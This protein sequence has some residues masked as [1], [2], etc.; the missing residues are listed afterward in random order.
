MVKRRSG[1]GRDRVDTSVRRAETAQGRVALGCEAGAGPGDG[2]EAGHTCLAASSVWIRLMDCT[3]FPKPMP[4]A[5]MQPRQ[6]WRCAPWKAPYMNSTP[7]TWY[8]FSRAARPAATTAWCS[9]ALMSSAPGDSSGAA[10][11]ED[12][13]PGTS[14]PSTSICDAPS[15][16]TGAAA[17][18][19]EGSPVAGAVASVTAA[20]DIVL[21]F[22]RSSATPE[23]WVEAADDA[24]HPVRP[25]WQ[26]ASDDQNL[27]A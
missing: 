5:R 16:P 15:A 17:A 14:S 13:P 7:A 3:V 24:G 10:A 11:A 9:P 25:G 26:T 12:S 22:R 1:C 4:S 19:F 21:F 8:S 23:A 27:Q 6:P 2:A 20:D 18:S